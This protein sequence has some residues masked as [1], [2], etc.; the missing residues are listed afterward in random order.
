MLCSP[1]WAE[2]DL[3]LLEILVCAKTPENHRYRLPFQRK[4]LSWSPADFLI[5]RVSLFPPVHV[6]EKQYPPTNLIFTPVDHFTNLA[7]LGHGGHPLF[8]SCPVAWL[9][10]HL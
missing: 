5:Y 9:L 4:H 8:S 7:I 1:D 2:L 6:R 10:H 3:R